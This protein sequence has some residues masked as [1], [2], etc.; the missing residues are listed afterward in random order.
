MSP[1]DRPLLHVGAMPFPSYQGT[2]ALVRAMLEAE[3]AAG[4]G[5]HLLTYGTQGYPYAAPF[6]VHRCVDWPRQ[7][8]LRSG[9]SA[10]K[11][12]VDVQLIGQVQ[13]WVQ[14][15]RPTAL[16]AHHVEAA[17]AAL[18]AAGDVPVVF[19]AHTDLAEELPFYGPVGSG[20]LLR[21]LGALADR[22]LCGRAQACAAVSPLLA[23]R[24]SRVQQRVHYLAPPLP[25]PRGA[26][27]C[28]TVA[29][30]R[31]GL[32]RGAAVLLYA[33][34]LDRYQ[35]VELLLEVVARVRAECPDVLLY[36]A[37]GSDPR[38]VQAAAQRFG[39]GAQLRFGGL[40]GE[41][42]RALVHAAA[43][44]V[45]V[46]RRAAGGVPIKL[47]DGLARGRPVVATRTACAG[48]PLDAVCAVADG[49]T[50]V[51]VAAAVMVLLRSPTQRCRLAH[52]GPQYIARAHS[53]QQYL[54][55]I[56]EVVELAGA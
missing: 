26:V 15:L 19:V 49:E 47:L 25:L 23:A 50:A 48:L 43:D 4:W 5:S 28:Q 13:R 54:S 34:N 38:G 11:L 53:E 39:V 29:R 56:Q 37:T 2:Q 33:G 51:A 16:I 45:L 41:T 3:A 8:S 55:S 6:P 9:P 46:P 7:T 44:L 10:R 40:R 36:L 1:W 22:G 21:V 35:G 31:L 18:V 20:P 17:V 42:E 30:E 12:W 14:R 24:L 27:P 52:A 32:P